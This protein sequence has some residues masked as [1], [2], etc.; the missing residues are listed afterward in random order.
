MADPHRPGHELTYFPGR[1]NLLMADVVVINKIDTAPPEG[2]RG[3]SGQSIRRL[4]PTATVVDAASPITVDHPEQIKGKRVLV[5]EDGPTLTHGE[6]AY[7]SGTVAARA[8][9]AAEIVDPRPFATGQHQGDVPE[10]YPRDR[11]APS[12]PWVRR[13]SRW[14]TWRTPSAGCPATW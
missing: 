13:R 2:D 3:R 9:G 5:V 6:M 11:R 7:G 12:R 8:Q 1:V 10:K 14:R 4:N